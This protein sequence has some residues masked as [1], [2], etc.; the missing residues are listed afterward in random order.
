VLPDF[1]SHYYACE[2]GPFRNLSD[3]PAEEAESLLNH[4]R[5]AGIGFASQRGDDYLTIRRELE[6]RVR[7]LFIAKG[8]QPQR[9]VPHY[10]ILGRCAWVRSWYVEGC[11]VC[12][13]LANFA[14][15]QVSFTYGDTFPAM[16]YSD[17]KPYRGQVYTLADLPSLIEHYGLPQERNPDGARG[18]D[19]YIEAQVWSDAPLKGW[20]A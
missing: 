1:L 5:T 13:P 2:K 19:R 7:A 16:R 14:A 11:E 12:V 4:L 18:P 9:S 20:L 10:M 3:L 6:A 15:D 17:G 8:G